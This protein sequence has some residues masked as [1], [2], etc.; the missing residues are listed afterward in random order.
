MTQWRLWCGIAVGLGILA[1]A[2][3]ASKDD[4]FSWDRAHGSKR[5]MP[6]STY[7]GGGSGYVSAADYTVP[8]VR[9][10]MSLYP[11]FAPGGRMQTVESL[12]RGH[13]GTGGPTLTPLPVLKGGSLRPGGMIPPDSVEVRKDP[14]PNVRPGFCPEG[15]EPVQQLIFGGTHP[16]HD[17]PKTAR[18][19]ARDELTLTVRRHN[20]FSGHLKV[21]DDGSIRIPGTQD[22]VQA[23]GKTPDELKQLVAERISP[24]IREK[25]EVIVTV[26]LA[27]G[28]FY[29]VFGEVRNQGRFPMGLKPIRLSEAVFRANSRRFAAGFETEDRT[30]A[31]REETEITA[32]DNFD[33]STYA[34]LSKVFVITPHRSRPI[35]ASY[36]VKT[37]ML[38]GVTGN[39]PIIRPGQIV[40][41]PSTFDKRFMNFVSRVI[42]PLSAAR[43]LEG[44][45][46]YWYGR[47]TGN[48]T[49][50]TNPGD[51]E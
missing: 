35:R 2:G 10:N 5:G 32:R 19:R 39:D 49:V 44:E 45:T 34:D 43:D 50:D 15:M 12:D 3:C 17:A 33:L 26:R 37:S 14:S 16:S 7:S 30:S 1:I 28:G 40:F 21:Q 36:N 11:E 18:L 48:R 25:P 51:L 47:V 41:V 31:L 42:A 46:N 4:D 38:Q 27:L 6:A 8:P 20:E 9:P 23:E 24:Y 22:F 29:Y 13:P